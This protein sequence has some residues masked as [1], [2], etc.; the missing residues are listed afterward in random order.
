MPSFTSSDQLPVFLQVSPSTL[1]FPEN[2]KTGLNASD[3][4]LFDLFI[5]LYYN[6]FFLRVFLFLSFFFNNRLCLLGQV[7]VYGKSERQLQS[8]PTPF[9]VDLCDPGPMAPAGEPAG[10]DSRLF[11][12]AQGS[13]APRSRRPASVHPGVTHTS[14]V[15]AVV[16]SRRMA[17]QPCGPPVPHLPLSFCPWRPLTFLLA[18]QVRL[19]PASSGF[20]RFPDWSLLTLSRIREDAGLVV[21]SG[22][23]SPRPPTTLL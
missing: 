16:A 3:L 22:G 5:V 21:K 18:L 23:P 6:Y 4:P 10:A 7:Q 2:A 20:V 15:P 11:T 1:L 13:H 17:S 9:V 12:E 19:S 8:S 14:R